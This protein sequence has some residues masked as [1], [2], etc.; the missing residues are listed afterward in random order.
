MSS[1]LL[2]RN[3]D[4]SAGTVAVVIFIAGTI[5]LVLVIILILLFFKKR[6]SARTKK[7]FIPRL[8]RQRGGKYGKLEEDEEQAWSADMGHDDGLG[9]GSYAPVH[10]ESMGYQSQTIHHGNA[11]KD[12][13]R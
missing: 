13:Y 12:T 2:P 3:D 4:K 9:K 10:N 5:I 8:E 7:T 1:T 6:R 11:L